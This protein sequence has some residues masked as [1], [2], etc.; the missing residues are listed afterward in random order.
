MLQDLHAFCT[1]TIVNFPELTG[2]ILDL[3]QKSINNEIIHPLKILEQQLK[4]EEKRG[5]NDTLQKLEKS[6]HCKAKVHAPEDL[7]PAIDGTSN[8]SDEEENR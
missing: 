7:F 3:T 8:T 5:S 4:D 1:E 2:K 6:R